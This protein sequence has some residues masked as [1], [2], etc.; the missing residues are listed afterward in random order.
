MK[1]CFPVTTEEIESGKWIGTA[2][3]GHLHL[4]VRHW[5]KRW[6]RGGIDSYIVNCNPVHRRGRFGTISGAETHSGE[7]TFLKEPSFSNSPTY[8]AI[9]SRLGCR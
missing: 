9:K 3:V 6:F 2:I 5:P 7:D 1:R 8:R 4:D